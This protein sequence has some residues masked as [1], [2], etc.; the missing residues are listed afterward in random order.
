MSEVNK[1]LDDEFIDDVAFVIEANRNEAQWLWEKYNDIGYST[2]N[3]GVMK[4]LGDF[5][6]M[7]VWLSLFVGHLNGVKF[8]LYEPTSLVVDYQMVRDFLDYHYQEIK[9]IDCACFGQVINKAYE[10]EEK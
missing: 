3:S 2:E 1:Q 8:V 10:K 9:K 7:P 4:H 5:G 6:G